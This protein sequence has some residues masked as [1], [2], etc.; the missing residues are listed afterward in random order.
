MSL[1]DDYL[2]R[3]L[4]LDIEHYFRGGLP[5]AFELAHAAQLENWRVVLSCE[6]TG[7]APSLADDMSLVGYVT[8]H[9]K[10]A[11]GK[12]IRTATLVWLDRRAKWVRTRDIIW[13]LGVR[14]AP[15][16]GADE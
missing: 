6:L 1:A 16:S 11:D 13:R 8:G 4:R 12:L 2:D 7:N 5:S 15:P 14:W 9:P 10:H 3:W